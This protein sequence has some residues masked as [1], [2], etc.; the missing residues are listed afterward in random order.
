MSIFIESFQHPLRES[1]PSTI[2]HLLFNYTI[3]MTT[4]V[5]RGLF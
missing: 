4:S 5:E 2:E 1:V 3:E